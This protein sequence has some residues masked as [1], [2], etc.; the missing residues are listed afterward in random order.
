MLDNSGI[1]QDSS[2][3]ESPPEYDLKDKRTVTALSVGGGLMVTTIAMMLL[4]ADTSLGS[5]LAT[6]FAVPIIGI[7]IFGVLLSAGRYLGLR[8]IRDNNMGMAIFGSVVLVFSYGWFGGGILHPYDPSL[9]VPALAVTG[10]IS[11]LI[12][13]VA[14]GV[15]YSTEKNFAHYE[16][17]S[18]ICFLGVLIMGLIGSFAGPVLI[19]AFGL[20]LAGFLFSLVYEIWMTSN[21]NRPAYANGIGLYVA[22]AG[23]FV[24]ILQMV[25]RAMA[26]Q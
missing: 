6:V 25:L 16:K 1:G 21:N 20:A 10:A 17:Y 13:L 15:V 26:E 23:V 4:I 7:L 14:A 18:G 9:Y 12:S 5:M 3:I 24:H 19:I 22:F 8:G 11:V 2:K